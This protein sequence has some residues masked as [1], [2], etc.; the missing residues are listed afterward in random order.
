MYAHN[1]ATQREELWTDLE[2]IAKD[3]NKPWFLMGDFNYVLNRNERVGDVVRDSEMVS[4]RRC[5][6]R[7]GLDDLK[8]AGCYYTWNNKQA[9]H[10]RIYYKLD[11]VMCNE[12][13]MDDFSYF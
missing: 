11:R 13:R 5:V 2:G 10:S 1:D 12:A 8:S 6:T 9:E 4:F 7:C 3:I